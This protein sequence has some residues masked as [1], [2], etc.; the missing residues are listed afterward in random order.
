[1]SY[2]VIQAQDDDRNGFMDSAQTKAKAALGLNIAAVVV[3][4][5]IWITIVTGLVLN[6]VVF[7]AAEASV[8]ASQQ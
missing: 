8:A 2:L 1:M 3:V 7:A 6:F 4:V 5:L